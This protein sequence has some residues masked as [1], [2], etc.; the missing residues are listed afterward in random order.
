MLV[1]AQM[2]ANPITLRPDTD[3]RTALSLMQRHAI[4]H[5]PVI[6]EDD[7]LAG[8]VAERDLLLAALQYAGAVVEVEQ[9]MHRDVITVRVD[10]PVTHAA[11]LMVEHAIGGLPVVDDG[12][13][14]VGVITETDIFRAFVKMLEGDARP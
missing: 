1:R 5:L 11:R 13:R 10:T 9:V 6:G 14:V 4:H 7:A 12:G 8:I 2:T 3:Y